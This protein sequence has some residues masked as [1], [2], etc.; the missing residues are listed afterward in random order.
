MRIELWS[1]GKETNKDSPSNGER[2]GNSSSLK[3]LAPHA[4]ELWPGEA[5][6]AQA[7]AVE[8]DLE[9][10]V[11]KCESPVSDTIGSGCYCLRRV[12]L[13][14]SRMEKDRRAVG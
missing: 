6:C 14:G 13:F 7:G 9:R 12:G 5:A 2:I 1:I 3:F 10:H 8:V 11:G 4:G